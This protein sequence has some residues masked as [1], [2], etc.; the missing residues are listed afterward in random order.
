MLK[1]FK[2]SSKVRF[3]ARQIVVAF[4]SFFVSALAQG[5][6]SDWNNFL[7]GAAGAVATTVLGLLGPHEPF[8][9]IQYKAEVPVPPAVAENDSPPEA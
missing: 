7:W 2:E 5:E 1:F 3:A 9:G 4:V 8:V 6:I